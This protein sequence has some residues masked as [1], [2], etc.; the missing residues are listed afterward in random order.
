MYLLLNA[1]K[2]LFNSA[3][4][5]IK[6][7]KQSLV[8]SLWWKQ[9]PR[10][11]RHKLRLL[12]MTASV[13]SGEPDQKFVISEAVSLSFPANTKNFLATLIGGGDA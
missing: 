1:M 11:S 3:Y 2:K 6:P 9:A 8:Y 4:D 7:T 10:S 12:R 13:R 5:A